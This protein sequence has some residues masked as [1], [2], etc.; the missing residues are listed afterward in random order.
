LAFYFLLN[1]YWEP[2]EFE[3]PPLNEG[4]V[5]RRWIDTGL[6]SPNDIAEWTAAPAVPGAF[7]AAVDRSVVVLVAGE[8]D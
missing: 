7:Y 8:T 6:P 2:R 3:L 4:R 5:W 1:G